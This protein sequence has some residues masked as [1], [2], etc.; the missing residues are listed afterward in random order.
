MIRTWLLAVFGVLL[1]FVVACA[2]PTAEQPVV[3]REQA[4][5]AEEAPAVEQPVAQP[6][7]EAPQVLTKEVKDLLAKHLKAQSMKTVIDDGTP[8]A[9][10]II[11]KGDKIRKITNVPRVYNKETFVNEI[12]VDR[13]AKTAYGV[14]TDNFACPIERQKKAYPR[15]FASDDIV[16][17]LDIIRKVTYA[18]KVGA[19]KFDNRET[20]IVEYTNA[21]GNRERL[22]LETYRGVPLQQRIFDDG[23]EIEKHTFTES[24][25]DTYSDADVSLPEGTEIVQ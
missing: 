4:P 15:D 6:P 12:Y 7:A 14:C 23:K 1:L 21:D 10:T 24:A 3:P 22:W 11:V 9:L 13:A 19:E 5:A 18:E 25:F 17:P 16:T 8:N 20:V 2:P